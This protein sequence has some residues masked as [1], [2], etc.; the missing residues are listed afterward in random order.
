VGSGDEIGGEEVMMIILGAVIGAL[1]QVISARYWGNSIF[2]GLGLG[3]VV[4]TAIFLILLGL[5]AI[6]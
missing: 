3:I 6:K 4:Y 2:M 1:C 5:G